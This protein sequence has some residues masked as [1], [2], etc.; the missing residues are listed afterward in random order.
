MKYQLRLYHENGTIHYCGFTK[1]RF[2][3][4]QF[5][6]S[7]TAD[8]SGIFTGHFDG[9]V[10]QYNTK[11]RIIAN[12][13]YKNGKPI[14]KHVI[15]TERDVNR[16]CFFYSGE[17]DGKGHWNGRG[18]YSCFVRYC[19]TLD[20]PNQ[21]EWRIVKEDIDDCKKLTLFVGHY[22]NGKRSG[23]GTLFDKNGRKVYHGQWKND[24]PHGS[25]TSFYPNGM[26]FVHGHWS[27][28]K[29]QGEARVYRHD[30]VLLHDG[31]WE[32]YSGQGFLFH[33]V[34]GFHTYEGNFVD[35]MPHGHGRCSKIVR[36]YHLIS[37]LS[38]N[39]VYDGEFRDG[40]PHGKGKRMIKSD[41]GSILTRGNFSHGLCRGHI[42]EYFTTLSN[43]VLYYKGDSFDEKR[44]G[45]FG[46]LYEVDY[47]SF[48]CHSPAD[49]EILYRNLNGASKTPLYTGSFEN[50]YYK[51]GTT[52]YKNGN[53]QYAGTFHNN[54]YEGSGILFYPSGKKCYIGN[55]KEHQ[56]V[57]EGTFYPEADHPPIKSIEK[58]GD[59]Y[60]YAIYRKDNEEHVLYHG[61]VKNGKPHG[62]GIVFKYDPDDDDQIEFVFSGEFFDGRYYCEDAMYDMEHNI[63]FE[64][65]CENGRFMNGIEFREE[66]GILKMIDWVDGEIF[67]EEKKRNESKEKLLLLKYLET[68]DRK[69][70]S[71]ISKNTCQSMLKTMT[72]GPCRRKGVS[73]RNCIEKI[74]MIRRENKT[75]LPEKESFDLFGN[76]IVDPV[77]GT[78]GCTYALE[79]MKQ[80][81]EIN[82]DGDYVNLKYTYSIDKE[83]IPNFPNTGH[84]QT[85]HG[86]TYQDVFYNKVLVGDS[87]TPSEKILYIA[88]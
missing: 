40:L 57:G 51:E 44:H 43:D 66:N 26:V 41:I 12:F 27:Y 15:N 81:F 7:K 74:I 55:W 19:I 53:I 46:E 84:S 64:G 67:H 69:L 16:P 5:L 3:S 14:A 86:F 68:K 38:P 60:G 75:K 72:K 78:D 42:E 1:S 18:S 58:N 79:S 71:A 2:V 24:Q 45:S 83:R 11:G 77:V 35:G 85:L 9:D 10:Y 37:T 52:Y 49:H 50:F 31:S 4:T 82:A 36:D 63:V 29:L 30:G 48:W 73:K 6:R 87:E 47:P 8:P 54:Q 23:S 65:E 39:M 28:G 88:N 34:F 20:Q 25:G 17:V 13:L 59:W 80:F 33:S 56:Q 21:L 32:T 76:E 62:D 61:H 22:V 70:L